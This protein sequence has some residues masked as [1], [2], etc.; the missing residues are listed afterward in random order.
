VLCA[1]QEA[2]LAALPLHDMRRLHPGMH[3]VALPAA[4]LQRDQALMLLLQLSVFRQLLGTCEHCQELEQ[5]RQSV[6]MPALG[7]PYLGNQRGHLAYWPTSNKKRAW[8][9]LSCTAAPPD[10]PMNCSLCALP[11]NSVTSVVFCESMLC[12]IAPATNT[13]NECSFA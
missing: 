10:P 2:Q 4:L 13:S 6:A 7:W 9:Y 8:C 3:A 1:L 12:V 11:R 5:G